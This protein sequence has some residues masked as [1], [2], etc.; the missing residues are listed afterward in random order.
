M[1]PMNEVWRKP[2]ANVMKAVNCMEDSQI[3]E[4]LIVRALEE[5]YGLG[6]ANA[7]RVPRQPESMG[8]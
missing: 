8:R 1:T 2:V 5:A 3:I 4:R 6:F 7:D